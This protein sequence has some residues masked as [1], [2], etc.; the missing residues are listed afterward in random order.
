MTQQHRDPPAIAGVHLVKTFDG[1]SPTREESAMADDVVEIL[2]D[3]LRGG[4]DTDV[5]GVESEYVTT[6]EADEAKRTEAEFFRAIADKLKT[7]IGDWA[8]G[9]KGVAF[10]DLGTRDGWR[11]GVYDRDGRLFEV[12][13]RYSEIQAIAAQQRA[14]DLSNF[15]MVLDRIVAKLQ[16][17]R[18]IWFARRDGVT[19]Q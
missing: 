3:G 9:K 1:T 4:T 7:R 11:I 14:K 19:L 6:L 15:E 16:D 8:N 13:I 12:E 2:R 10:G 17:A 18:R 5:G